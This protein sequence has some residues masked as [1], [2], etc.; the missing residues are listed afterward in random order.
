MIFV[1]RSPALTREEPSDDA[2]NV[3]GDKFRLADNFARPVGSDNF[4]RPEIWPSPASENDFAL[5]RL[6][7]GAACD[8]HGFLLL[9][10]RAR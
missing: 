8:L 1:S 9:I 2:E 3:D 10:S 7:S 6:V 5:G 4:A